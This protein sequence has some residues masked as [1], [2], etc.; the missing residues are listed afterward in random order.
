MT[1]LKDIAKLTGVSI[2]TVS[3]ALKDKADIGA[4]TK[5]RVR[6]AAATLGYTPNVMARGLALKRSFSIGLIET[7]LTN[8]ARTVLTEALRR[9]AKSNGYQ[10]LISGYGSELELGKCIREMISRGV[11]GLLMCNIS[12]ILSE[13]SFW[14]ELEAATRDGIPSVV[15]YNAI[16]NKIDNIFVDYSLFTEELTKHLIEKHSLRNILFA[17]PDSEYER[18][19]GYRQAMISAGLEAQVGF[20]PLPGWT[21]ADARKG[22]IKYLETLPAPEAIVCHNDLQAI[23]I[24]AG[25][26]HCGIKTPEDVA[27]VGVDN[28]EL[29]DYIAPRLS[30]AGINPEIL[31]KEAFK[32]L[33]DRIDGLYSGPARRID[34]RYETFFRESCGCVGKCTN[35]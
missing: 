8:P 5:E 30:T 7:E 17:A 31:A 26:R 20:I 28:I 29:A 6:A 35:Q 3:R 22:I 14:P 19:A 23:G 21:M 24:L 15:F 9:L 12:G 13:K 33:K 16:S 18:P 4:S 2:N 1:T 10:L 25:L 34:L 27:V 11:D 32:L